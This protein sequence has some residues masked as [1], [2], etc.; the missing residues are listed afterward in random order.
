MRFPLL[1]SRFFAIVFGWL[2]LSVVCVGNV[3]A[4]SL[5]PPPLILNAPRN[6]EP[7]ANFDTRG[8]AAA[9]ARVSASDRMPEEPVVR[10]PTASNPVSSAET[11][12]AGISMTPEQARQ[13]VQWLADQLLMY[14]PRRIDGDDDWGETKKVWAG[15]KVRRDGWELKTHRRWKELRHGR[16]VRYEIKLP[17]NSPASSLSHSDEAPGPLQGLGSVVHANVQPVSD[18]I[19]IHSVTP[20]TSEDGFRRW[21]VDASVYTPADFAVRVERWNLGTQWYSIEIVG[22]MRL[23]MRTELTMAME[24]DFSEVPPAM[25]LD[26]QIEKASLDVVR[27]EVDRISKLGGDVAE[28]IG[29][30]AEKTI[31]KSWVRK[32]NA[33]LVRRLNEAIADNRDS[34]RWSMAGW[35]G[36]LGQ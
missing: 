8:P 28:E 9:R 2:A 1:P 7:S 36:Q 19:Q 23:R 33:R 10:N 15:V 5:V 17:P 6:S 34:L 32:E 13:S 31:G 27:F 12:T 4:Q 26:V 30:L 22:D 21:H 29:D 14:V 16:W 24:A 20:V 11:V 35:L 25:Q 3:S 18:T